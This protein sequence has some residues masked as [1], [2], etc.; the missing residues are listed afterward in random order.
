MAGRDA[1]GFAQRF[2]Q[3]AGGDQH[4]ALSF[5]HDV[6]TRGARQLAE[7]LASRTELDKV[8]TSFSMIC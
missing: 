1:A 5:V 2:Q 8:A 4:D 7:R 3:R 6:V